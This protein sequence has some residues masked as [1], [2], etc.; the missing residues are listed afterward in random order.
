MRL[1]NLATLARISSALLAQ[2][3]SLI[4][5]AAR[6]GPARCCPCASNGVQ[7]PLCEEGRRIWAAQ[8]R[9]WTL[10]DSLLVT[11]NPCGGGSIAPL[12]TTPRTRSWPSDSLHLHETFVGR[13]VVG[14]Y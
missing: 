7:F 5:C 3:N 13:R 12:A 6:P 9:W 8:G 2:T 4:A 11:D 10:A 1:Q 14:M